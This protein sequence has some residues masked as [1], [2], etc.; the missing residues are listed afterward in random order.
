MQS[1]DQKSCSRSRGES[2]KDANRFKTLKQ[3]RSHQIERKPSCQFQLALSASSSSNALPLAM[4][5]DISMS[6]SED[7]GES[8]LSHSQSLEDK[9]REQ[10][11]R[12]EGEVDD[13]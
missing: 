3:K 10:R 9:E 11:R 8:I 5:D 1:D 6:G 12:V 4:L 7:D 2:I 13:G